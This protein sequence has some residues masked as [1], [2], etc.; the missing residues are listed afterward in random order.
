MAGLT[1]PRERV[2][3]LWLLK[4]LFLMLLALLVLIFVPSLAAWAM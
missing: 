3:K 2:A 4:L 1:L